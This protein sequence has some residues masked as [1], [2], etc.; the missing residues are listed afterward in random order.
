MKM[1]N[2]HGRSAR[3]TRQSTMTPR[4]PMP[5]APEL[6]RR[7]T[8]VLASMD[9]PPDKAKVLK[10]YEDE[11]KWDLIRDQEKVVAKEPPSYY[12][13]KIHKLIDPSGTTKRQRKK[14]LDHS[15]Q[16]V[17]ELEI[18]LRTN[19]IQ[20]VREFL[21]EENTG[22]DT[23]IDYLHYL[24][25]A[26][27]R[28][29]SMEDLLNA[30]SSTSRHGKGLHHASHARD[31][32]HVCIMC[33]RAIMNH[34]YGFNLVINHSSAI[35]MIALSLNHKSHRTKTLV[36]EL[37]AAVCLVQGGHEIILKAFDH[38]KEVSQESQR[39]EKLM[40]YFRKYEDTN[41]DIMVACM[42]FINIVVH[43]VD[44]MNY[45]VHLQYEF[46]QLGLDEFLLRLKRTESE[47]LSLQINA[48]LDNKFDVAQ[49]LEDAETKHAA[50][51]KVAELEEQIS[52]TTES[53]QR[54]EY[55]SMAKIADLQT[56]LNDASKELEIV[57]EL[58][59]NAT[60]EIST[61]KKKYEDKEIEIKEKEEKLTKEIEL[62]R[63][64]SIKGG[65]LVNGSG[66]D[67]TDSA[68][69]T[70]AAGPPPPAP[71]PPPP[72]PPPPAPPPPPPPSSGPP[73]PPPPP[74]GPPP[75]PGGMPPPPPGGV[76]PLP[77][78]VTI[79]KR[80]QTKYRLPA[81]NWVA[82]KPNQIRGTVFSELD[83]D[84]VMTEI[85]F[86]QFE[87]TFKTKAQ[88][89]TDL[90]RN[91]TPRIST[92]APK[93]ETITLLESNRL[94]N[95]SISKRKIDVTND[96]LVK[97]IIMMDLKTLSLDNVEMLL[98]FVPQP[99]EVNAYKEYEKQKKSIDKLT[100]ED[101]LMMALSKIERLKQKLTM[102]AYIGNFIDTYHNLTPQLK[103]LI[104]ASHSIKNSDKLKKLL[105]I[106][107]A[108][109]NYMNSSKRGAA[110]GFKLQSLDMLLETKSTDGKMTLLHYITDVVSEK[111]SDICEFTTDLM[112]AEKA[113]KANIENIKADID[114]LVKGMD[115]CKR[116]YSNRK[117]NLVLRDFLANSEDKLKK[118]ESDFKNA[119]DAYSEVV[120]YYGENAK[121]MPPN[122]FFTFFVRFQTAFKKA[123]NDNT[124]R[125]KL[126]EVQAAAI[127][128]SKPDVGHKHK[129]QNAMITELRRKQNMEKK[130]QVA[131][132]TIENILTDLKNEP[133]RR[134]D[135]IRRSLRRRQEEELRLSTAT[136]EMKM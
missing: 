130:E 86:G 2:D 115:M 87:E 110:Y 93:K 95:L 49:L 77:G 131:D 44:D 100:E 46:T 45:R 123:K 18:S 26:M 4:T 7:F 11:K 128:K 47:K 35:N 21:S 132:G 116:E 80:V 51:E 76:A 88:P 78:S 27:T 13:N 98:K 79:K 126:Q 91:G 36:L 99:P 135:A 67:A 43:S 65:Q 3:D 82:I 32:V 23:L 39:F 136:D 29:D 105:E 41:I 96:N 55:E 70:A 24:Q 9:L 102:M 66:V 75:P 34:Q 22:L 127:A 40:E 118:L 6:E 72:P 54:L 28:E 19:H 83:D 122:T 33:L 121:M 10:S 53:L 57:K 106:I 112:Y 97:G 81:L 133:Y 31:D 111:Y 125:R 5:D 114:E 20:W 109:G 68:K 90:K 103:A 16:I 42:Q 89:G 92:R 113:S 120:G 56:H 63:K 12:I 14:L 37:L 8:K 85:D 94:Q 38:F 61:L 124:Q 74:G 69:P 15:T 1:G 108:F 73:P 134:A 64:S 50:L 104:A 60:N 107:L 84:K 101:K 129:Q 59:M 58:N 62:L 52:H 25:I 117:D 30:K 17:R 71:P 119:K 48:Y